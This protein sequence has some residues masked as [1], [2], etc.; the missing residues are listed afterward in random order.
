MKAH[1]SMA[2][3]RSHEEICPSTEL[4]EALCKLLFPNLKPSDRFPLC[5]TMLLQ[6][7]MRVSSQGGNLNQQGKYYS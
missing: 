2:V 5:L 1:K 4:T 3:V 7:G 6:E